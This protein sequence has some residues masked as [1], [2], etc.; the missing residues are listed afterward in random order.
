MYDVAHQKSG[1]LKDSLVFDLL[2]EPKMM[3]RGTALVDTAGKLAGWT[4][5]RGFLFGK[6]GY[7]TNFSVLAKAGDLAE[8]KFNSAKGFPTPKIG[9]VFVPVRVYDF[10]PLE[11]LEQGNK[12][13]ATR[14][15]ERISGKD[16]ATDL[17]IKEMNRQTEQMV[18]KGILTRGEGERYLLP[19]NA[20]KF[21]S[22]TQ[23]IVNAQNTVRINLS[24]I[25]LNSGQV[26]SPNDSII[27]SHEPSLLFGDIPDYIDVYY[28]N[29]SNLSFQIADEGY[30]Y[31]YAYFKKALSFFNEGDYGQS[32]QAA[33]YSLKKRSTYINGYLLIIESAK[34]TGQYEVAKNYLDKFPYENKYRGLIDAYL[35]ELSVLKG[36]MENAKKYLKR[37]MNSDYKEWGVYVKHKYK[38]D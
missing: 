11:S 19:D 8:L 13:A 6:D 18:Q 22:N 38:V 1:F 31:S 14:A 4:D 9:D 26:I 23:D 24:S 35:A 30:A 36:D 32:F 5:N 17:Q 28:Y 2:G 15:W 37:S 20:P 27:V 33:T 25:K 16:V 10:L 34:R 7:M 21:A 3:I 29:S 12:S